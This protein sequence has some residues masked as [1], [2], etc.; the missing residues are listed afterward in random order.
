MAD[1]FAKASIL[2]G[3][4][5]GGGVTSL[6]LLTGALTLTAGA[7]ISVTDGV[8]SIT[9]A[10]TSAG[11]VTLA[12]VGSSPNANA[13]TL[14]SQVLN[15]QPASASFPGVVTT[16]TQTLAGVKTFSSA[17]N[18]SS[19]TASTTLVLDG[20]K[21]VASL[22]YTANPTNS[23]IVSRDINGTSAFTNIITSTAAVVSAAQTVTMDYGSAGIQ[24]ISGVSTVTFT[25]P[26]ATTM[27]SS[28]SYNFNNNSTG[29]VTVNN[30]G[31]SLV[32]SIPGGG[33]ALVINTDNS[34]TNGTW[35]FHNY[36]S[37][38]ATSG[39]I[40]TNL[41][42]TLTAAQI[43]D[44]GLTAST[45]P[46]ANASKQLTSSA[47][48]P[49]ELGYVSGVTSAI[50]T[51]LNAKQAT[52]SFATAGSTPSAAGG[53]ISAG[54]I[55]LQPADGTNA[56]LVSTTTQT[57][58]GVK[59]LTSPVLVTPALGTPASGVATNLT[60]LPLTT[61]V[62]GT[63]PIANGGTNKS[64]VTIAPTASSW[65]GWDAN[66]NLSANSHI[67]G[68]ATT[69]T[70]AGTTTLTV[71]SA[72]Q[73][74]FT[75]TTTQTVVLPVTSTLVLG[76]SFSITN[77]STGIV[78]VQSS[79][80]NNILAMSA[81]AT[82]VYTCILTSGTGIA[83]W[84]ANYVAGATVTPTITKLTTGSAQTYTTPANVAYLRV[85]MCGQGGGG[86]GT[87]S[88]AASGTAGTTSTF[89]T[90]LLSAGGGNGA[91]TGTGGGG[92]GGAATITAPAF[93][94]A[95][96]GGQGGGSGRNVDANS[97]YL[98]GGQGGVNSFGG[99]GGSGP[100]NA[101][102]YN[103]I[104]NTGGGGGGAGCGITASFD[105]SPGGGAGGYI[106]AIIPNPS[107]TYTYTV[108]TAAGG[109][110]AGGTG[111]GGNGGSGYI[112]ITE[113]YLNASLGNGGAVTPTVQ[114]L[115]SGTAATYT[116]PANVAYIRVRAVGQGGGGAGSG[117]A[118]GT[119]A[120][121][122]STTT[123]GSS[124]LTATGGSP[125]VY[126]QAAGGVGG[127]PTVSSPAIGSG[128]TGTM[129]GGYS[130]SGQTGIYYAGASG[131]AAP[132]FGGAGSGGAGAG[133]AGLAN[134][135]GGGAGG[136]GINTSASQNGGGGGSGAFVEAII[137]N[138]SA[139]YTYTIG[140][141]AGAAGAAGTGGNAGGAGGSGYIEIT[142]YYNNG[143]IGTATNVTGIVAVANGGTGVTGAIAAAKT[144]TYAILTTDQVILVDGTSAFTTTL[145]T[146]VGVTGK[147]YT[148]KRIDQTLANAV[149]IATTSSQTIDGVTTRKLMTQYEQFTVV[150]D[151][152][153]WQILSHDYPRGLVAYTPSATWTTNTTKTGFWKRDGDVMEGWV[154]ATLSGAP[155][156]VSLSFSIVTG[157]TINTAKILSTTVNN[158]QLGE[159]TVL[160][161]STRWMATAHLGYVSTTTLAAFAPS[162]T[163]A[164]ETQNITASYPM[165][166]A[167]GDKVQAHFRVPITD[168]EP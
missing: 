168:W 63:L 28:Q 86:G 23:T 1:F 33:Y 161:T 16:G 94:T 160:D 112:E 44:S 89:G 48:T 71:A 146:A 163:Q 32:V 157:L 105:A 43:I 166:F 69:A 136:A 154:L 127:T 25:L 109:G 78:T 72:F 122:G 53:G 125:G 12:A 106:D 111:A 7:G 46:Y 81:G 30:K 123:F 159:V 82:A 59:T 130:Y 64:A 74:Y 52:V 57:F 121:A 124:L 114:K 35:D 97:A 144:T 24:R 137:P 38:A 167:S 51:Q 102:G 119:V 129:G 20:S 91:A 135:G 75:G 87:G 148:I 103:G 120:T 140:S 99:A 93:G 83:S 37:N 21:N 49:T 141:A 3:G 110:G 116:T 126:G 50:Q 45:V 4:G 10:S 142:E 76:Q 66:S 139:T 150:S 88:G 134:T 68:Y 98:S 47:V 15:L 80:A 19:L 158:S 42:G 77:N 117:T 14:A 61:G 67:N 40:G 153:N 133:G 8:S 149:T 9:I 162:T 156:A 92:T 11:D 165:T 85:R 17:P 39:T 29:I 54:V 100:G 2:G 104:A 108:G 132:F 22:A 6:D 131:G 90:S 101:A 18:L 65:A 151:G 145:P 128:L 152:T 147:Q 26:D 107:A 13:A 70:A 96:T 79:G 143:A 31:G 138:P 36:L 58:A 55:T 84:N 41:P 62:T 115:T 56:G 164:G 34:T 27:Y 5:G 118:A 155:D 95:R 60:G 73:Q 113:Y